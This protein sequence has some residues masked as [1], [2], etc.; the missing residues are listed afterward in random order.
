MLQRQRDETKATIGSLR[1]E[2][3][4]MN[5]NFKKLEADVII[6]KKVNN[7]S[8][9]KSVKIENSAGQ[10]TSALAENI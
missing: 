2:L 5:T 7:L 10:M 9:K 3:T 8:M 6:F 1:D 4:A